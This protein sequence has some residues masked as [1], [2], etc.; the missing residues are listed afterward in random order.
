MKLR[1]CRR[2]GDLT[3]ELG[4]WLVQSVTTFKAT[5]FEPNDSDTSQYLHALLPILTDLGRSANID[6]GTIF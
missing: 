4:D 2:S 1:K 6:H 5:T 3:L